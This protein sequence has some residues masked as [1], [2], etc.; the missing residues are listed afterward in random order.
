MGVWI[1]PAARPTHARVTRTAEDGAHHPTAD[2]YICSSAGK[3]CLVVARWRQRVATGGSW[4]AA[5]YKHCC[6]CLTTAT[7]SGILQQ[8]VA[9]GMD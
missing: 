4:R 8:E 9:R 5:L 7:A 3:S 1:K 2:Y 6:A